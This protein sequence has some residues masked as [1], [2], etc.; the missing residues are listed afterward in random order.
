VDALWWVVT[1]LVVFGVA[2]GS[3]G[4]VLLRGPADSA[5]TRRGDWLV[6]VGGAMLITAL[7]LAVGRLVGVR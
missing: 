7:V 1:I 2:I 5:V 3:V 4:Q 6:L